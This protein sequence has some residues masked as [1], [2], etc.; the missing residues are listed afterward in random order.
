VHCQNRTM[1][2]VFPHMFCPFLALP[3]PPLS[4]H[5]NA[6]GQLHPPTSTY[7]NSALLSVVGLY[8]A[9]SRQAWLQR[10]T[11]QYKVPVAMPPSQNSNVFHAGR[12]YA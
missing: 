6:A 1:R 10:H 11:S 2:T 12:R 3:S 9:F 4:G 8:R 5:V 7:M